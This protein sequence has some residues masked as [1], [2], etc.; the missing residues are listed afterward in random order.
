MNNTEKTTNNIKETESTTK[1]YESWLSSDTM[2][3]TAWPTNEWY[4]AIDTFPDDWILR[5]QVTLSDT[6]LLLTTVEFCNENTR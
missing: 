5:L 3:V 1:L 6:R 4:Q 2:V